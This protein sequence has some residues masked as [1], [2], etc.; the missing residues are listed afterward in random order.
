ML[1]NEELR[2]LI[3]S[4]KRIS[5]SIEEIWLPDTGKKSSLAL[6]SSLTTFTVD[7]NRAGRRSPKCTFQLREDINRDVK[8]I[9]LDIA[10]PHHTNPNGDFP[11][12]GETIPCPHIHIADELYGDSIAYPLN[13][14][15]AKMYLT[16][17]ELEDVALILQ[18]F[19][20]RV[21]TANLDDFKINATTTLL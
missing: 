4:L 8:L 7:L 6:K 20:L 15:Y 3:S 12:A 11:Y 10:G 17:E 18:K 19:L 9:R 14:N 2:N 1:T 21:N 13:E 16:D 5:H